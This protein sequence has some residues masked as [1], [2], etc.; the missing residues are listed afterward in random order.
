MLLYL[1]A[2]K[3]HWRILQIFLFITFDAAFQYCPKHHWLRQVKICWNATN[4]YGMIKN[5]VLVM[6]VAN[7]RKLKA[8]YL[9]DNMEFAI[10]CTPFSPQFERTFHEIVRFL[11]LMNKIQPLL[12]CIYTRLVSIKSMQTLKKQF[13]W[14]AN[15]KWLEALKPPV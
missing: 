15:I 2:L 10:L 6:R 11:T 5:V 9:S 12:L 13:Q 4:V 14:H 8:I 1:C 3:L 7:A